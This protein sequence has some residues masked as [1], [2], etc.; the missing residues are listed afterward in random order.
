MQAASVIQAQTL[1]SCPRSHGVVQPLEFP[2]AAFR[3]AYSALRKDVFFCLTAWWLPEA[4]QET[5]H[6]CAPAKWRKVYPGELAVM[7]ILEI[8]MERN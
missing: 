6:F 3:L 1:L 2:G 4:G 8:A 7:I 5:V